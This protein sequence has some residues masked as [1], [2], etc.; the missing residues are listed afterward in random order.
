LF[1]CIDDDIKEDL[2][3]IDICSTEIP[4]RI[5]ND[6]GLLHSPNYP[7]QLGQYLTCKKQL[8]VPRESRLRLFML[9]KSIEYSHEFNIRLLDG[10]RTLAVNELFDT[11]ITKHNDEIVQFELKTNHLGGGRFLLYFQGKV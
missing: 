4:E 1:F 3:R 7:D 6:R 8:F 2:P 11:N 5:S 9:E 10:F